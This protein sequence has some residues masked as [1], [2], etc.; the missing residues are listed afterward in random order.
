MAENQKTN[1][2]DEI[3]LDLEPMDEEGSDEVVVENDDSA[4]DQPVETKKVLTA[5]DGIRELNFKLE[6]EKLARAQA[7][8]AARRAIEMSNKARTEVDDTNLKLFD[9]AMRDVKANERAFKQAYKEALSNGDHEAAADIQIKMAKNAA[10]ELALEQGKS[11]YE[12]RM[13]ET[14]KQSYQP[15]TVVNDPVETFARQ[16]SPL[17]ANWVRQHPQYVTDQKLHQKMLAAHSLAMADGIAPDSDDYF[18]HVETTLRIENN[19]P[20]RTTQ[21]EAMSDSA[22]SVQRR[23]STAPPAAPVSRQSMSN[24]GNRPNVVRLTKAERE[25]ARDMGQTE[26]EYAQM[27]LKLINEG[28]MR[29]N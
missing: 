23:Q 14:P 27:K 16:L 1:E 2:G 17:S 25:A 19:Q 9:S 21:D 20:V 15:N 10:Q 18:R 11:A 29:P 7:D 6:Q 13:R 24:S 8:E 4:K 26:K 28:R 5:D 22:K 3:E 12:A